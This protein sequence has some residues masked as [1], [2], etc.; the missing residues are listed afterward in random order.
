MSSVCT[1]SLLT[2]LSQVSVPVGG[3]TVRVGLWPDDDAIL[4]PPD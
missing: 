4:L 2:D 1:E 3:L